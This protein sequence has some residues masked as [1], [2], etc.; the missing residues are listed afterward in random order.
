MTDEELKIRHWVGK[1]LDAK[2]P[3]IKRY[4][5]S[6]NHRDA[7]TVFIKVKGFDSYD[8]DMVE[9]F[10]CDAKAFALALEQA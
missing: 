7:S 2:N 3:P 4:S 8:K 9:E 5:I 1:Q 6:V 10:E